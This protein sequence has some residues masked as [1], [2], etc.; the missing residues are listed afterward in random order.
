MH[1]STKG[2]RL[3]TENHLCLYQILRR[4]TKN[5]SPE[6]SSS[7]SRQGVV[8]VGVAESE[9]GDDTHGEA[10]TIWRRHGAQA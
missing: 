4:K 2:K 7:Y 1:C 5:K 8:C 3:Q 6:K 10:Q 9:K